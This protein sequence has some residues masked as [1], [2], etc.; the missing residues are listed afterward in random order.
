M[1]YGSAWGLKRNRITFFHRNKGVIKGFVFYETLRT[2]TETSSLKL[3]I[4]S[5]WKN[6]S[7]DSIGF[8]LVD[9]C[10]FIVECGWAREN[11]NHH[12]VLRN[13][14]PNFLAAWASGY[15]KLM[16]IHIW[17]NRRCFLFN[18]G[19]KDKIHGDRI[20]CFQQRFSFVQT[21]LLDTFGAFTKFGP[22]TL[23][24]L[25]LYLP[26]KFPISLGLVYSRTEFG[27][28]F[29]PQE[30]ASKIAS[31]GV[32]TPQ[33]PLRLA[34]QSLQNQERYAVDVKRLRCVKVLGEGAFGKARWSWFVDGKNS[35]TGTWYCM[36]NIIF[37][38]TFNVRGGGLGFLKHQQ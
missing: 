18:L 24:N 14:Y 2:G 29:P 9:R 37:L 3:K 17:P 11:W 21:F 6:S 19:W 25:L 23:Q 35:C 20:S 28:D 7:E 15:Q 16:E 32:P 5:S 13:R 22:E 33:Q 31:R 4:A 12:G 36:V 26:Q 10:K 8:V 38:T 34:W 30:D 1:T 27:G